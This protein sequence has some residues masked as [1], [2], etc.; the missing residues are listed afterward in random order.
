VNDHVPPE[1]TEAAASAVTDAFPDDGWKDAPLA[2][3][4]AAAL[5]AVYGPAPAP[6]P[7]PSFEDMARALAYA[8]RRPRYAGDRWRLILDDEANV[9]H[10][11]SHAAAH[12]GPD[13]EQRLHR[14]ADA[15]EDAHRTGRIP[16]HR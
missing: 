14:Y 8:S 9:T 3:V 6:P 15:L 5:G 16:P 7:P 11:W 1:A 2:D 4:V 13:D 10:A 12:V